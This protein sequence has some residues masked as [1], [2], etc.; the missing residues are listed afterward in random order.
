MYESH[1]ARSSR[2][3]GRNFHRFDGSSRRALE[4][5][6]LLVRTDVEVQLRDSGS[7]VREQPL[8]LA[9]V[10]IA[11]S[12]PI[13]RYEPSYPHRQHVLVVATG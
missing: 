2:S 5:A 4:P 13:L 8:E 9:D 11:P 10:G 6:A 3:P 1:R 7:R 12:A